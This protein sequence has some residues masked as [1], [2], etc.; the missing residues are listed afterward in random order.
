[1]QKGTNAIDKGAEGANGTKGSQKGTNKEPKGNQR[2][3]KGSRRVTK[4]HPHICLGA[5]VDFGSQKGS[6]PLT[7][8]APFWD[9]FQQKVDKSRCWN[10]C[11]NNMKIN[12]K[13]FQKG[14][15]IDSKKHNKWIRNGATIHGQSFRKS[16]R[17]KET[18]KRGRSRKKTLTGGMCEIPKDY[19]SKRFLLGENRDESQRKG[20]NKVE[21]KRH[22]QKRNCR[23]AFY[24]GP[25]HACWPAATCGF[26]RLRAFRL[27]QVLRKWVVWRKDAAWLWSEIMTRRGL[28]ASVTIVR[29]VLTCRHWHL[30]LDTVDDIASRNRILGNCLFLGTLAHHRN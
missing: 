9:H 19:H 15:Q 1:M 2:Q 18:G 14:A 25:T 7:D 5:R 13:T 28:L 4:R 23:E 6:I 29:S 27:A 16:M 11:R 3:L 10:R 20:A 26:N 22:I 21:C 8:S 30:I 12:L 17:T 24:S